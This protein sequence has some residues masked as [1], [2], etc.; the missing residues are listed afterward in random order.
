MD[1]E[2]HIICILSKF[3]TSIKNISKSAY[4]LQL[5]KERQIM[6]ILFKFIL[7]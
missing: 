5:D 4:Y 7:R 1:K 2:R 3:L 6:R